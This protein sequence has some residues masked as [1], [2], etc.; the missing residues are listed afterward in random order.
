MTMSLDTLNQSRLSDWLDT[1]PDREHLLSLPPHSLERRTIIVQRMNYLIKDTLP[2]WETWT[3]AHHTEE[4]VLHQLLQ[5]Q[6]NWNISQ[7]CDELETRLQTL[8]RVKCMPNLKRIVILGT[9]SLL[10]DVRKEDEMPWDK[11]HNATSCAKL[12]AAQ[13]AAEVLER[14]QTS[15][16]RV[17]IY[18]QNSWYSQQDKT[19]LEWIGIEVLDHSYGVQEGFV[20]IDEDTLVLSIGWNYAR[21][22]LET[23]RPACMIWSGTGV[24]HCKDDPEMMRHMETLQREYLKID[25]D[26]L[27]RDPWDLRGRS[28]IVE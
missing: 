26:A 28:E 17:E 12:A 24:H 1:P 19:A 13:T 14:E 10:N 27:E 18:T 21:H 7:D 4:E 8:V 2:G 9:G 22:V 15:G 23:S 5:Y 6:S 3:Y 11:R 20:L 25:C 16:N